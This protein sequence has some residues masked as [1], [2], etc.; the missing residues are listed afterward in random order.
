M[1]NSE[2]NMSNKILLAI[3][4]LE[5]TR[6]LG[7]KITKEE[8][9]VKV[10]KMFPNEFCLRGYPQYPNADISKYVTKLFK[11]NLLRGSFYNY[12]ITEKGKEYVRSI[13]SK[14]SVKSSKS[15]SIPR[16]I[17]SEISRIRNSKTF[18]LYLKGESEFIESDL[19]DF[20]GTSSRSFG[21]SNRT[22]F[23]SR[24]NLISKE[25]IP[26]CEKN[27]NKQIDA[28]KIILLWNLLIT[29]FKDLLNKK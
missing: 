11:E 5:K 1:A 16:Q 26:F 17:E 12:I 8:M 4:E 13:L 21:D 14:G 20:L 7:E 29:K 28:E 24:Y 9:V 19:F 25:V 15:I 22:A 10:W 23:I 3:S 2:S 18:Q 6:K 27:K